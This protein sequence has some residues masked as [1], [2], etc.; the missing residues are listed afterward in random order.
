[1]IKIKNLP[2]NRSLLH[3]KCAYSAANCNYCYNFAFQII[4]NILTYFNILRTFLFINEILSNPQAII[5]GLKL[6]LWNSKWG[7]AFT[8]EFKR[9]TSRSFAH[10]A[11]MRIVECHYMNVLLQINRNSRYANNPRKRHI[12]FALLR[13]HPFPAVYR[14][15]SNFALPTK[16]QRTIF[17]S[18]SYMHNG[19]CIAPVPCV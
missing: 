4:H 5:P 8:M 12:A 18:L 15:Y 16:L 7:M 14:H 19:D 2:L 10:Q 13:P 3:N 11:K 6:H 17:K 1:M 9:R